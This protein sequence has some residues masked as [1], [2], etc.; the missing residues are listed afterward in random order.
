MSLPE[1]N[2]EPETVFH[3]QRDCRNSCHYQELERHQWG[4]GCPTPSPLNSPIQPVQKTDGLWKIPV[5]YQKL[6][7]VMTPFAAATPDVV[8]FFKQINTSSGTWYV[9]AHLANNIFLLHV[10]KDHKGN[11]LSVGKTSS[12]PLQFYPKDMFTPQPCVITQKGS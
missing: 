11:L 9:D 5:D 10:H 3:P 1:K 2:S 6:N 4:G 8:S 7:E 12:I